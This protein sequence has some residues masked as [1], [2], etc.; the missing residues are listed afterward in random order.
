MSSREKPKSLIRK[1][2]F[3]KDPIRY[4]DDATLSFAFTRSNKLQ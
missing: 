1:V 4:L 2:V 3:H